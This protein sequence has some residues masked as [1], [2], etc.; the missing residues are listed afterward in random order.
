MSDSEL[1]RQFTQESMN[2]EL[3]NKPI[4]M[5]ND[6]VKFIIKMVID[7]MLELY[8]TIEE[9]NEAKE[10]MIKM[11]TDAKNVPKETCEGAELIGKQVDAMV[12]SYYYTLNCTAK[13]GVDFSKV[14]QLVHKANMDKRDTKT[15]KFL[16]REDGKIIK[17]EGWKE[18][19]ITSEIERQTLSGTF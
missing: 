7:E 6:E 5:T 4:L 17:P 9:P 2:V 3:P 1:V 11:I 16:R 19:D 10:G 14:F 13:M 15:G 8:A 18:P 12:D